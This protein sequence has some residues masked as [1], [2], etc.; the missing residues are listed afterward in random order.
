M[1][2]KKRKKKEIQSEAAQ[3]SIYPAWCKRC[4]NCVAFCPTH[5]LETDEWGYP[6]LAEAESCTSCQLC[7]KLCPDFA[8]TVGERAASRIAVSEPPG[9]ISGHPA[10]AVH[11]QDSPERLAS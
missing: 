2:G 3:V 6:H 4:G 1:A 9:R 11:G 5:A 8:I 7:E 10:G